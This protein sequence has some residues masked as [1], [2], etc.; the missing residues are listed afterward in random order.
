MKYSVQQRVFLYDIFLKLKSWRKCQRK[1]LRK[2]SESVVPSKAAIYR[3][4]AKFHTVGSVFNK[5]KP[6]KDVLT[7]ETLN[8]I[9]S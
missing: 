9:G 1:F 5:K 3:I 4:M 8:D 6:Q 7:E 2:F